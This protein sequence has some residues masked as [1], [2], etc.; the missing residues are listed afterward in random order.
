MNMFSRLI[1]LPV[2]FMIHFALPQALVSSDAASKDLT[3]QLIHLCQNNG[4]EAI[5]GR[6]SE[7]LEQGALLDFTDNPTFSAFEWAMING[8]ADLC[9]IFLDALENNRALLDK[10][11]GDNLFAVFCNAT[12]RKIM[13]DRAGFLGDIE[14]FGESRTSL[15]AMI[16]ALRSIPQ[17]KLRIRFKQGHF[18]YQVMD[19]LKKEIAYGKALG[20]AVSQNQPR[21]VEQLIK[22]GVS[23]AWVFHNLNMSE[24]T[25]QR[26][27]Q[28]SGEQIIAFLQQ[29]GDLEK[30]LT[31][32]AWHVPNQ[33]PYFT[34]NDDVRSNSSSEILTELDEELLEICKS[35]Q[36]SKVARI[37]TL[38]EQ[39]ARPDVFDKHGLTSLQW[40]FIQ[41]HNEYWDLLC[42]F[43]QD[44]SLFSKN[45]ILRNHFHLFMKNVMRR[46]KCSDAQENELLESQFK[47][48]NIF[49]S[50]NWKCN[51]IE[52][53]DIYL[54]PF[55]IVHDTLQSV[56]VPVGRF[57]QKMLE[58]V[59]L[60]H[61]PVVTDLPRF[62]KFLTPVALY[63]ERVMSYS[64]A[65]FGAIKDNNPDLLKALVEA[66]ADVAHSTDSNSNFCVDVA[67]RFGREECL[68]I[69]IEAGV[70]D[71]YDSITSLGT[72]I[73]LNR[74][75]FDNQQWGCVEILNRA[76]IARNLDA[77]LVSLLKR[78]ED[79]AVVYNIYLRTSIQRYAPDL[80]EFQQAHAKV[81]PVIAALSQTCNEVYAIFSVLKQNPQHIQAL[82]TIL[83]HALNCTEDQLSK[84]FGSCLKDKVKAKQVF[85]IMSSTLALL[86]NHSVFR[87][88]L[89]DCTKKEIKKQT[90]RLGGLRATGCLQTFQNE[91][92]MQLFVLDNEPNETILKSEINDRYNEMIGK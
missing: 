72:V 26:L 5:I 51:Y 27:K 52:Y 36:H 85:N 53:E 23:I 61:V 90:I 43:T 65:A 44:Q 64:Q 48:R 31:L 4:P 89:K 80:V 20:Y 18:V 39:G 84:L 46:G 29:K 28:A 57:V 81:F 3:Q 86:K 41:G 35:S 19:H 50:E 74:I 30:E 87:N 32:M 7:L 71:K 73:T 92:M 70:L 16:E 42:D 2:I 9:D 10:I 49:L 63:L 24:G 79:L 12:L 21:L 15:C 69:L 59:N 11:E 62:Q 47:L 77:A 14:K 91:L 25:C 88:Y 6:V 78:P 45:H 83:L 75:A 40:A 13:Q 54:D 22:A 76:S 33:N 82:I 34:K 68:R 67:V 55:E 37:K 66:G 38:L 58:R 56:I 60:A 8:R 1:F 17:W